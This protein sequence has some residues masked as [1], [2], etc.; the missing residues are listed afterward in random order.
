[1]CDALLAKNDRAA[2]VELSLVDWSREFLPHYFSLRA[3]PMHAWL[4]ERA[5]AMHEERGARI[6]VIGPRGHAKSTVITLAHVLRSAIELR[7]PYIWIVSDTHSQAADHLANIKAEL[8]D[9]ELLAAAYPGAVGQGPRWRAGAI[10]LANGAVVEAYGTGQKIRGRRHRQHRPT[11]I[12][13]DDLENDGHANSPWL[14]RRS[15]EWFDGSLLK[16]GTGRTNVVNLATALHV[17][18]LA[19]RLARTPGW[20]SA[21]FRAIAKWPENASL[22]IEWEAIYANVDNP[23]AA[24]DAWHYYET[25]RAEM[26]AGAELLW[27]EHEELYALMRM[28]A[29]GGH[30]AFEREKQGSPINPDDC[31]WPEEYFAEHIWFDEWPRRLAIRAMALDPSKGGKSRRGDYSAYVL[32]GVGANGE[33]YVEADLARRTTSQMV[34]DGA[35]LYLRF[36]PDTFGI[37]ANQFQDLLAPC[38]AEEFRRQRV[39][40]AA[41]KLLDNSVNKLVRIRRLGP[42]LAARRMR[43]KTGSPATRLLV[44]QL[45]SFPNA[46]HDD[47]PD[48]LEMALRLADEFASAPTFDDGLGSRLI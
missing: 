7:E 14:R 44:E 31:E 47:G 5:D 24:V 36:Q 37:E 11:L 6:N 35:A 28:R 34:A 12:V 38:F 33:F 20:T 10:E 2:R 19:L 42:H 29:E 13:C 23:R 27:P 46:D 26:D 1:M 48:A 22:W 16:A 30:T 15:R 4:A 41:A 17:E 43:F 3:S 18:A 45:K 25:H 40:G 39:L 9:N 32:L 8:V 21:T